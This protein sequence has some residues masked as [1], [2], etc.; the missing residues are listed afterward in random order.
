MIIAHNINNPRGHLDVFWLVAN[1]DFGHAGQ[2]DEGQV[3][4]GVG[5]DF[6]VDGLRRYTLKYGEWEQEN[7][8]L[9]S[10]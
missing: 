4:H 2:I 1:W 6:E 7:T 5:I 9:F 3:H 10:S 8:F